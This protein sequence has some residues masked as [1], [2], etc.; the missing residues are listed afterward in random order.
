[1]FFKEQ[2]N[3][4]NLRITLETLINIRWIAVIGQ[5]FTVSF[6]YYGLNFQFP[7]F[8][9]LILISLSV[10][11]NIFLELNKSRFITINNF[12]ATISIF[13]DLVQLVVL[14]FMTGG[15]SNPFSI[16]IIVPTT[17]SVTYLSR[18]SSQFIVACSIFCSTIIAIYHLPLP[19]PQGNE[20]DLPNFYEFG[21]WLSLTIGIVFLGNYAYQ[22]G[23]DNRVRAGALNK[24]EEELT[25]EKV[26]NSVGGMA[27]AAVHELAT[28]L[29]TI[30][31]VGKELQK[32]L[33]DN[34][35]TKDDINLLINQASRCSSILKDIA[36]RKQ[37]DQFISNVSPKELINEIIFSLENKLNKEIV[38]TNKSLNER[39]KMS[40]KTEISYAL[41]NFIE[42][43]IKFSKTKIN[44]EINQ[45]K[46]NTII[47]IDDDGSGFDENIISSLGQPYISSDKVK[48]NIQGMG[49]GIFIS[50][51]LLER[52]SAKVE[53][54]NKKNS[55]AMI[56][57]EWTN[58]QLA[59]L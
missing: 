34:K 38:V 47:V 21:M 49:L 43:A 46:K 56:A 9:T 11:V 51:N 23:R 42:N 16:L 55:G 17:I 2:I 40:K 31:L 30:S 10:L 50:K 18:G 33:A 39:L 3:P 35:S 8:E 25:N 32:Q 13:Y 15:L 27:A 5:F 36:E 54:S 45:Q 6:V 57:I 12:Y 48:Q 19:T 22:L 37:Q 58:S 4:N 59:N 26:V 1:M 14:L 24:L 53:F 29:A 20:L 7:Y 44:I 41:R 52:C 28:P